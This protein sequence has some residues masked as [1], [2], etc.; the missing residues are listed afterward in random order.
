MKARAARIVSIPGFETLESTE[1][2]DR[3]IMEA[4]A[5]EKRGKTHFGL[6]APG[7][8]AL[9]NFDHSEEEVRKKFPDTQIVVS[10]FEKP[11][12]KAEA[13][14]MDWDK[15]VSEFEQNLA[16]AL[17]SKSINTIVI[18]TF[19]DVWAMLRMSY[20]GKLAQVMPVH[21]AKPNAH[22]EGIVRSMFPHDKDVIM[23]HKAT[24]EYKNDKPTGKYVRSGF[25]HMG[26]LPQLNARLLHLDGKFVV[27]I[28]ESRHDPVYNGM[29]LSGKQCTFE[30][31]KSIVLA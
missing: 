28:V 1:N 13:D 7:P 30:M 25:T 10:N 18:D 5:R 8:I 4:T 19:T 23:L 26:Y 16:D 17:R 27:R 12:T 15:E 11:F 20:F 14:A 31:V 3:L 21:Y 24:A 9:F 29:E 2:K 6:G 22:M